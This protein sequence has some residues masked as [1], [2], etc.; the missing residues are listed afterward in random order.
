M[1]WNI[2]IHAPAKGATEPW[3]WQ[4]W[5]TKFQSTLPQRERLQMPQSTNLGEHFN[6]R[7]RKG[8]DRTGS[9]GAAAICAFQSTLPQRE[10]RFP[11]SSRVPPVSISIHAPAKGATYRK[12]VLEDNGEFQSTLPQRERLIFAAVIF[13]HS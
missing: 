11:F 3:A 5:M 6:P 9:G 1:G 4:H 2:S 10:R 7:S 8:S 12:V 13:F